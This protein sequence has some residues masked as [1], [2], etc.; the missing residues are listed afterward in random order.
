[1][2]VHYLRFDVWLSLALS[3]LISFIPVK[4]LE[5]VLP[6][7]YEN[8][9]EEHQV[10]DGDIGGVAGDEIYRAQNVEDLLS[11]ETFT[12][13][14]PGIEYRNK[15]G[16]YH[17]G[18]YMHA[19]TLPSGEKIA[20]KINIDSVKN[21]GDSIYSGEATLPVGCIVYEDL[22]QDQSF[23]GQIEFKEEL[24]RKDFY[25]DMLGNGGKVSQEYYTETPI[26][27]AQCI[28]VIIA[29]PIIHS[30]GARIGIFPYFFG[31]IIKK[32]EKVVEEDDPINN[33]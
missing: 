31:P 33:K 15:G 12:V 25:I 9:V 6:K 21:S 13:I 10:A 17:G 18:I 27:L 20:A 28:T 22:S 4:I 11:H 7:Q 3:V 32:K 24:T 8:Y 23:L 30:L 26:T 19:L 5:S 16:G 29:F 14:S 2:R 1:M